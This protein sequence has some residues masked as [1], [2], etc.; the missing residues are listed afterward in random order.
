VNNA[1][2]SFITPFCSTAKKK[3]YFKSYEDRPIVQSAVN[4]LPTELAKERAEKEW[5]I[6]TKE[7]KFKK[8][9]AKVE[10]LQ[11]ALDAKNRELQ[12][13]ESSGAKLIEEA[14]MSRNCMNKA[15][16]KAR[17]ME[18]IYNGTDSFTAMDVMLKELSAK[19]VPAEEIVMGVV[20]PLASK[21]KY[22]KK[23]SLAKNAPIKAVC[24]VKIKP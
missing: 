7:E 3:R 19:S 9:E 20:Q 2:V 5:V 13:S 4:S 12:K 17:N 1:E 8:M 14:R 24:I 6:S 15:Y 22:N 10:E 11:Q 16:E 21:K 18:C 23:A